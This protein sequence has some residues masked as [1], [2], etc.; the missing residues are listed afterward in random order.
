MLPYGKYRNLS[1][2]S[3]K[4]GAISVMALDHRQN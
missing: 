2:C 1:Q 4:R 3:T